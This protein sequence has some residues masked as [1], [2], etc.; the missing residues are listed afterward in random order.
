MSFI[1]C[2]FIDIG[3]NLFNFKIGLVILCC[4]QPSDKPVFFQLTTIKLAV[5]TLSGMATPIDILDGVH[6]RL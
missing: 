5:Q 3:F 1:F 2:I 6:S 4:L